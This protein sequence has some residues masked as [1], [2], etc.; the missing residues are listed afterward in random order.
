MSDTEILHIFNDSIGWKIIVPSYAQSEDGA[1]ILSSILGDCDIF[2][3]THVLLSVTDYIIT[4]GKHYY[5]VIYLEIDQGGFV[6][7][8]KIH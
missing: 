2:L 5:I 6:N 1:F 4:D 3:F 8:L 7:H